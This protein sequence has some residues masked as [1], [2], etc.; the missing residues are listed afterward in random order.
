MTTA[1]YAQQSLSRSLKK[2]RGNGTTLEWVGSGKGHGRTGLREKRSAA[3]LGGK[4]ERERQHYSWLPAVEGFLGE[5]GQNERQSSYV[6]SSLQ[7][8]GI[9]SSPIIISVKVTK[10]WTPQTWKV[11]VLQRKSQQGVR[12]QNH[13]PLIDK[14]PLS[15]VF[16][17][18][19]NGHHEHQMTL[20]FYD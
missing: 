16:C 19:L 15:K 11:F 2:S 18:K 13:K 12:E 9:N 4:R 8:T 5:L 3:A 14:V 20:K 6:Y 10:P 7:G 1:Y 17:R